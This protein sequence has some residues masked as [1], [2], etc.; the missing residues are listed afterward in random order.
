MSTFT[1]G[2]HFPRPTKRRFLEVFGLDEESFKAMKTYICTEILKHSRFTFKEPGLLFNNFL[3]A[4]WA[5][6]KFSTYR[7]IYEAQPE[8]IM[9][10]KL[11][12]LLH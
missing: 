8:T 1:V 3:K 5:T 12:G 11:R 9:S 4:F 10:A 6:P 2:S 7:H